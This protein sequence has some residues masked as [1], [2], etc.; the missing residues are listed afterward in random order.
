MVVPGPRTETLLLAGVAAVAAVILASFWEFTADDAYIYMRY[1]ENLV[2]TGALVFNQG[3]RVSTMTSPL[4][5]LLDALLYALTGATRLSYK[6]LSVGLLA[7]TAVLVLRRLPR[8]PLLRGLAAAVLLL[9][10]SVLLWTVG[11]MEVPVHMLIATAATL[12][13]LDCDRS[14]PGRTVAVLFLAGLGTVCR[15]DAAPYMVGLCLRALWGQRPRTIAF[16]VGVGALLPVAWSAFS[17]AYYEDLLPTSF[18]RKTPSGGLSWLLT[19]AAYI[20]Q[21]LLYTGALVFGLWVVI[22]NRRRPRERPPRPVPAGALWGP[23]LGLALQLGYAL[24]MA[25]VHM[26]FAFR[27]LVPYLPVLI[28]LMGESARR[29]GP[30]SRGP[31]ASRALVACVAL[32]VGLQ[33]A[34]SVRT[35]R[36]SIQGFSVTGELQRATLPEFTGSMVVAEQLIRDV[37]A[38]WQSL[39]D[40]P[41]RH[42]RIWTWAEGIMPHTYRDAYFFGSLISYRHEG[43]ADPSWADY[44]LAPVDPFAATPGAIAS[45]PLVFNGVP[46]RMIATY[47]PNPEPRTL[48][49]TVA[50]KTR[51]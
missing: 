15:Q 26:M 20:G 24:T 32:V 40:R 36:T 14:R 8:D 41:R 7:L 37:E 48:P 12:L 47:N 35:Y 1:G 33:I 42:P 11:G 17:L 10:P 39:P 16:A 18:Y 22:G 29:A 46:G 27:A 25:T 44:V 23:W 51:E 31:V 34:Q 19:N 45:H 28:L 38:H 30:P 9:S 13:A 43:R 21:F 50:G 49:P 4:L 3:E 5:A 6:I 2:D